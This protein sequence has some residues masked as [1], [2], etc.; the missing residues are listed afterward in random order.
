M[1]QPPVDKSNLMDNFNFGKG[2]TKIIATSK[3]VCDQKFIFFWGLK[4]ASIH[5]EEE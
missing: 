4:W 1:F 5:C 3:F 2:P